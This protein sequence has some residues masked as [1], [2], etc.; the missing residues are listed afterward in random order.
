MMARYVVYTAIFGG[1]DTLRE[2]S[3]RSGELDYVCLTDSS[4]I[5]SRF[6]RI[7][8]VERQFLCP[9]LENRYVKMLPHLFFPSHDAS[10]YVD[11]NIEIRKD[12]HPLFYKYRNPPALYA[13]KHP[14]R[15]CAYEEARYC[16]E[17]GKL[18]EAL[19]LK[20][21]SH[22]RNQGFPPNFGLTENA[23][24]LRW[25]RDEKMIQAMEQWWSQFKKY[26]QRD[27][28]SLPFILWK[29]GVDWG[30]LRET[31][32]APNSGFFWQPH[33]NVSCL[34]KLKHKLKRM[35]W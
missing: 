5:K 21:I 28:I 24:L 34:T 27:Q 16:V 6:W 13:A 15:H 17:N 11:G 26:G 18:A 3:V 33:S 31:C 30:F 8:K 29:N 7:I 22:Y 9:I 19:A 2:P 25:H 14:S 20:Q 35:V 4:S 32:R 12:P 10:L 23:L 1:Y